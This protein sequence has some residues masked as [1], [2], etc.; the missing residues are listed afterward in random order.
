MN[1]CAVTLPSSDDATVK[2]KNFNHEQKVLL[3][4]HDDFECIAESTSRNT[5]VVQIHEPCSVG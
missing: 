2:Y 5:R 1:V 3:V 4:V